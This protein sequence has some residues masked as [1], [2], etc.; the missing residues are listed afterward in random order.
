MVL[1]FSWTRKI[2]SL[3]DNISGLIASSWQTGQYKY[4]ALWADF[5]IMIHLT[6]HIIQ[7]TDQSLIIPHM[8][9][10]YIK[11]WSVV[12]VKKN[13]LKVNYQW[14][15]WLLLFWWTANQYAYFFS[16]KSIHGLKSRQIPKICHS[17]GIQLISIYCNFFSLREN[18]CSSS[19]P[20][21]TDTHT[22]QMKGEK[23]IN[24]TIKNMQ[25]QNEPILRN[26][27]KKRFF[28]L[29]IVDCLCVCV[30]VC[31]ERGLY[32]KWQRGCKRT[33]GYWWTGRMKVSTNQAWNGI[34]S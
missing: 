27:L 28:E 25:K 20:R 30:C 4:G 1:L 22:P 2:S 13:T 9:K 33:N 31:V 14:I 3:H 15:F 34:D 5:K 23:D 17:P 21:S 8:W 19:A 16:S 6:C 12:G 7:L 29:K 10:A 32:E 26:G 18:V 11:G 24:H